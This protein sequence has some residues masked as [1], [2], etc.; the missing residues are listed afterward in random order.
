MKNTNWGYP[1]EIVI[2]AGRGDSHSALAAFD[3]ALVD[4]GVGNVSLVKLTSILPPN[5]KI[6]DT[7]PTFPPGSNVPAIYTSYVT[8]DFPCRIA[9]TL[10]LQP[11]RGGPILVAETSR[12]AT[13]TNKVEQE[14]LSII[15]SMTLNRKI[16]L[17]GSPIIKTIEH[18][19]KERHYSAVFAGVIYSKLEFP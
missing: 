13:T 18:E 12:K 8:S 16:Q 10:V 6:L 3:A 5:I 11:T 9:A 15:E 2:V 14:A 4:A 17:Q 19:V 1:T 7:P